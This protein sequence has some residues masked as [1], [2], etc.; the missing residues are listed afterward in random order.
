MIR[1][2]V[3]DRLKSFR[4]SRAKAV[5]RATRSPVCGGVSPVTVSHME[6]NRKSREQCRSV[7]KNSCRLPVLEFQHSQAVACADLSGR[8]PDSVRRHRNSKPSTDRWLAVTNFR[9]PFKR[10]WQSVTTRI[11]KPF[12]CRLILLALLILP[13]KAA[14]GLAIVWT[15]TAGGNWSIIANWNPNQLPSAADDVFITNNG[16]YTVTLNVA[17]TNGTLTLGGTSGIQTLTNNGQTLTLN[18]VSTSSPTGVLSFNNGTI[19][20]TGRLT[21]AGPFTWNGGTIGGAGSTFMVIAN[22]GFT[23]GGTTKSLSGATLVNGGSAMW[24]IGQ[25]ICGGGAVFSNAPAA[26]FDL[27]ADG[28]AFAISAGG[29]SLVNSGTFRKSAGSG[30]STVSIP[31]NNAGTVLVNSGTLALALSDSGGGFSVTNGATL[32]VSGTA[33]LSG[34]ASIDGLGNFTVT[35][36]TI[37]NNGAFRIQGTNTFAGGTVAFNG[38]CLVTNSAMI[39]N[40]G[41][42]AFNGTGTVAPAS[43]SLSSGNLLGSMT[44]PISGLSTWTGGTIGSAGSS[45]VIIASGGLALS[46]TTKTLTAATLVNAAAGTWTNGVVNCNNGAVFSNAPTAT[47]DL[48]ADGNSYIQN[49]GTSLLFNAGTL[50]K[51]AGTGIS[52]ISVPCLNSGLVL[53]NS[54]TLALTLTNSGGE[55]SA[56]SGGTLSVSGTATLSASAS[57]DGLGNFTVTA[58]TITNNGVFQ[59]Q[60]TNTF[61]GGTVAFNGICLITNGSMIVNNNGGTV[62]F[63]GTGTVAPATLL[64]SA[65]TLVGSMTL[66]VPG[67]LTWTGA[68]I[69]SVGSSLVLAANG[70]LAIS[71]TANKTFNGGLL[72]NSVAGSWTAGHIYCNNTPV[73]S[74]APAATFD[75]DADGISFDDNGGAPFLFNAG[76][77]RK[78]GGSGTSTVTVSCNNSGTILVNS[79]TLALTVADSGGEFTAAS[80]GTLAITG[81][82]TLSGTASIDGPGAFTVAAGTI[83]NNGAFQIQ[84]TSTFSGGAVVLNGGCL[85]TNGA[86]I[87]T[88]GS[89]TFNGSGTMAPASLSL[90]VGSLLGNMTIPVSG[91]FIWSS[92]TI[93]SAGSTLLLLANAGLTVSNSNNKA[94]NGGVLVN[95]GAGVW[96]GGQIFCNNNS[97]FSNAASATFDLQADGNSFYA[98]G[99]NPL[100]FNAGTLRKTAGSGTS[101]FSIPCNNSGTVQVN[102]GTLALTFANS[103][104]E[105]T[106]ATGATLS[107]NGNA[108]LSGTASIDGPGSFTV[109]GGTMT[110]NGAFQIQGTNTFSGSS[111]TSVFNGSTLITNGPLIISGGLVAF[112]G[113]GTAAPASLTLSQGTL[114]GSMTIAVQG[115]FTWTGGTIGSAGSSPVVSANGSL[116]L[117]GS[118]KS[119]TGGTLLNAG[120]GVWSAGT[121]F[122]YNTAVFSNASTG[123]FDLPAD[124]AAFSAIQGNPVFYNAGTLRKTNGSGTTS[125]A[126]TCNNSGTVQATSG[127]LNF[128]GI[129][130]QNAGQTL[131]NGGAFSFGHA[132]QVL[133]GTMAGSGTITG[134]VSNSAILS[135]GGSP[136]LLSITGSYTQTPGGQLQIELG[137]TIAGTSYDQLTVGGTATLAGTLSLSYLNGFVPVP[138]NVFTC[139]VYNIHSGGFTSIQAPTNSLSTV[140]TARNLLVEPGNVSPNARISVDLVQLAGHTF[141][142]TGSGVDPDGSVTN[143]TL[144]QDTNVL[145]SA[146][147]SSASTTITSDF[148]GQLVFTAQATDNLGA[149]GVTNVAVTITNLPLLN[150][151]PIGFQTNRSFKLLM[152]GTTGSNYQMQA[153]TNL[154]STNWTA[155]GM[156]ESTNGIW[157]YFDNTASN[158]ADRIYRAE[159]FP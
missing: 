101:T 67:L 23:L 158:N 40:N 159:E 157:R 29:Q 136:G 79:G 35:A 114:L 150:L 25:I 95:A 89:I 77:L 156:M 102:S 149:Q 22:G 11:M 121:V 80:G 111:A 132:A 32:S 48:L 140:Y 124:G 59:V 107:A 109:T 145:A 19:N 104:G 38:N 103:S 85:V 56:A 96:A 42:V 83:T 123:T 84:G 81:N 105:F 138:G 8:C 113:S 148:P 100:A 118:G 119:L 72:I 146:N 69:G 115:L 99:G 143:L 30:T 9:I 3:L 31:C 106:V 78:T 45:L 73:F 75:L 141:R 117:S 154:N 36:G 63:N 26:T 43:L 91:P 87:I 2:F 55:F 120:A 147:G 70:G 133:S 4:I 125:L 152:L 16:T 62:A 112:N 142:L 64:L 1:G 66:A 108:T 15:N 88:S 52:T 61:A 94:F 126:V 130:T 82:A 37:T 60:G 58:G 74:N 122:C 68:T 13:G 97:V 33:M 137:G 17:S 47:F 18:G 129:Y 153:T 20:G 57:I 5:A 139:M 24:A 7:W 53:A 92:G 41:T 14:W 90:S 50:R 131:L 93:G 71:G 151:D 155:L 39:V 27:L 21:L 76:T 86:I 110:N 98:N 144:F 65:G 116:N 10:H 134:S 28:S 44:L 128:S 46:G 135:P 51:T 49:Q 12:F 6:G 127:T 54:G 34:S